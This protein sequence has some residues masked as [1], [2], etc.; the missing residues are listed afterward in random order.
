MTVNDPLL[1]VALEVPRTE[2]EGPGVRYAVWV[3]GCPMRCPG[4]CNAE[5]LA[6]RAATPRLASEIA[7]AAIAADV[8]GVSFLGGEPFAQAAGLAQVARRVRAAG[9]TVMIYSGF[10]LDELR[11]Q[12]RATQALLAET[13]LLVDGRYEAELRT[14]ERRF[15]GSTNQVVHH[16]SDAYATNDKRLDG[17]NTIEIRLRAGELLLNGWPAMGSSTRLVERRKPAQAP[18]SENDAEV[19]RFV[20]ALFNERRWVRP[21]EPVQP[22]KRLALNAEASR[23]IA[24]ACGRWL[25]EQ[26]GRPPRT[27]LRAGERV[28]GRVWDVDLVESPG[29]R[30]GRPTE[31]FWRGAL[32]HLPALSVGAGHR[33]RRRRLRAWVAAADTDTGDWLFYALAWRRV[34]RVGLPEETRALLE[35]RMCEGSPLLAL[36][37]L[38][39][40]HP[41]APLLRA[42][43]RRVLE[44][45]TDAVARAWR[46]LL[47]TPA[48][49]DTAERH[50]AELN[51]WLDEL[52]AA[53][54]LDLATPMLQALPALPDPVDPVAETVAA[55]G[56]LRGRQ[57][58]LYAV[59]ARLTALRDTCAKVR[60]GDD[61]YAEAQLYV[62]DYDARFAEQAHRLVSIER[63]L[64][65]VVG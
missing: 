24:R 57:A 26:G 49:P 22:S 54:R 50:A 20:D 46:E 32:Q 16:L 52:D 37:Q 9:L 41:T 7:D 45:S 14:T 12:G 43:M 10:T 64:S 60:Y 61:R 58:R 42:P 18:F 38:R 13:D 44:C 27:V 23:R 33:E 31:R 4:C 25:V 17:P 59:G 28:R 55:L 15:V 29:L 2:A 53:G 11:A 62:A 48:D 47:R 36:M 39:P 56:A 34:R 21:R 65:G 3:Q 5:M 19:L 6:D 1:N 51:G 8:A 35:R 30:F 63:G 40:G